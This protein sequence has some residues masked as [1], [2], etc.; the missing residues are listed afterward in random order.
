M[1][2]AALRRV[3]LCHARP[4]KDDDG[5]GG[6][7]GWDEFSVDLEVL[8]GFRSKLTRVADE[9]GRVVSESRSGLSELSSG[10]FGWVFQSAADAY[11]AA[12]PDLL[13]AV[14]VYGTLLD[15]AA[16]D[17]ADTVREYRDADDS[18]RAGLD[19]FETAIEQRMAGNPLWWNT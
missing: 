4:V 3:R 10:D 6:G 11:N 17:L 1:D 15:G 18:T 14:R 9:W 12:A 8:A 2:D 16:G 13:E 7:A 5:G 19:G